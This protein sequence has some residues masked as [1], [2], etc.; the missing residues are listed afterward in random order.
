MVRPAEEGGVFSSPDEARSLRHEHEQSLV[1]L[2]TASRSII[3]AIVHW[4][5]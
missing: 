2:M 3:G 5:P 4:A 1:N